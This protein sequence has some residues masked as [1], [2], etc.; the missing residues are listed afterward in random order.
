MMRIDAFVS[1]VHVQTR[2]ALLARCYA[3]LLRRAEE[4]EVK[5]QHDV[6][7]LTEGASHRSSDT[8]AEGQ[9]CDVEVTS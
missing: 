6:S 9:K 5:T 2:E 7:F 8:M 1:Q 3:Y 4:E